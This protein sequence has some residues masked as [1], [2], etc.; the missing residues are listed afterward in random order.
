MKLKI[1][2]AGSIGCHMAHAA[3]QL[4]WDVL[5]CDIDPKAITRAEE[6]TFPQRYGCWDDKITTCLSKDV[7]PQRFDLVIIGTPPITHLELAINELRQSPKAILIEKPIC[8]PESAI[9]SDFLK[10]IK[11]TSTLCFVGYD[12]VVSE[13]M[14]FLAKKISGLNQIG[15]RTIDVEFK[16]SWNGILAAHP[17]LDSPKDSYLAYSKLGGGALCEHSHG[18]NLWLYLARLL[19]LGDVVEVSA[20]FDYVKKNGVD[21]DQL[22]SLTLLTEKGIVGRCIQDMFS[23]PT[24]KNALVQLKDDSTMRWFCEASQ[25]RDRVVLNKKQEKKEYL[26]QKSRPDDFIRELSHIQQVIQNRDRN[27]PIRIE[28]GIETMSI[29]NAAFKSAD[30]KK[31]VTVEPNW[32]LELN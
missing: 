4:G 29:I 32:R 6:Q 2:G 20:S 19:D 28:A 15:T 23:I 25:G 14:E 1:V 10:A 24:L 30:T 22:S 13:S 21:Y 26:F 27:S 11:S 3:R 9:Y 12:H 8:E 18:I 31:V 17:W 16:E 5:L 7:I